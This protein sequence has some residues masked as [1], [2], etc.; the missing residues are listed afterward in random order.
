LSGHQAIGVAFGA[1]VRAPELLHGKHLWCTT[2]NR[3]C[4]QIYHHHLLQLDILIMAGATLS[5]LMKL[6]EQL[7]SGIVMSIRH[8]TL[9]IE[10]VLHPSQY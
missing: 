5:V 9:P 6:Q 7:E 4:L 1:G 8:R 10:G 2:N 3:A